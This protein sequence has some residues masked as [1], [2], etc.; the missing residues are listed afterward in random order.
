[1]AAMLR[2]VGWAHGGL[3]RPTAP[4]S[5]RMSSCGRSQK[6][7]LTNSVAVVT[8]STEA[9]AQDGVHVVVSCRKQ[10][11]M[12]RRLEESLEKTSSPEALSL[13][14]D[15]S[16]TLSFPRALEHRGSV[17]FLVCH[18]AV[19]LLVG[20]ILGSSEQ[21][22]DKIPEVNVKSPALLL[23]QLQPH[24]EERG[25]GAAI[26]VSSV[27]VYTPYVEL[28]ACNVGKLVLLGV[29]RMLA[30][31]LSPEDIR[32]NCLVPGMI[33]T[34]FSKV[35]HKNEAFWKQFKENLWLQGQPLPTPIIFAAE[36]FMVGI[37]GA[38]RACFLRAWCLILRE[39]VTARR[40]LQVTLT[41]Q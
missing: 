13:P 27:S 25:T 15:L 5:V 36:R 23:S 6:G 17:D 7:V 35:F 34:D 19:S 24:M 31:E 2:A 30:L 41:C 9:L 20:S 16:G 4:L 40:A 29:I 21:I 11:N 28:R 14:L 26:P 32:V 38:S 10:Q 1:M 37:A 3:L 8:G 22:W 18:A 33:K 12:D 39:V